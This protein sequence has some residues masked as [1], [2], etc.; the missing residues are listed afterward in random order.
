[1]LSG[2][3]NRITELLQKNHFHPFTKS[4]V[5]HEVI[6]VLLKKEAI[7][8]LII[9]FDTKVNIPDISSDPLLSHFERNNQRTAWSYKG[10]EGTAHER[11]VFRDAS[12]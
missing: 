12:D 11:K 8:F 5:L 3:Y 9:P 4:S 10:W 7:T 1:M 6:D 2:H